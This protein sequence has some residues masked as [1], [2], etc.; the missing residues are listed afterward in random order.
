MKI[1][2]PDR[3]NFEE[4]NGRFEWTDPRVAYVR[5]L[6]EVER[7]TAREIADDIG[8]DEKKSPRIW[9]V[10]KR[11]GISLPGRSSRKV[12][13]EH[14]VLID[15]S[16]APVLNA[17]AAQYSLRPKNVASLLLNAV[18]AQGATFCVNLLDL[19]A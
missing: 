13:A 19:E 14:L 17:L 7:M 2:R 1:E 9:A 11:H 4:V 3:P 12:N 5:H 18:L 15:E 8:L 10:A 6:A 16:S